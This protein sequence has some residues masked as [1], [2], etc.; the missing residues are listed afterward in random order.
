MHHCRM[1]LKVY[2]GIKNKKEKVYNPKIIN[3]QGTK[4]GFGSS[5]YQN[6]YLTF[7]LSKKEDYFLHIK[8]YHGPHVIIFSPSPKDEE[9]LFASEI[10]LYYAKKSSGEVYYTQRKNVKKVPSSRGKVSFD[11]YQVIFINQIREETISYLKNLE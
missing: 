9:I 8:D 1:L 4:I 11:K 10:C 5:S 2:V 7:T 3:F 6:E